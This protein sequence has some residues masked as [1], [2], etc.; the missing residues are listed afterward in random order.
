MIL[1]SM[2]DQPLDNRSVKPEDNVLV[3]HSSLYEP[4]KCIKIETGMSGMFGHV[5]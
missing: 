5:S 4:N 3:V 2:Q 1:K